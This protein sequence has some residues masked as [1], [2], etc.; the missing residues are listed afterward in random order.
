M[1]FCFYLKNHKFAIQYK[2]M[3]IT[4]LSLSENIYSTN[5]L[6]EE[7]ESR[8]HQVTVVNHTKCSIL[9]GNGSSKVIFEGENIL[10]NADVIIP[11]IGYSVFKHGVAVVKEFENNGIYTTA[12]SM[13]IR[14]SQ[15]KV[16]T[17][18][19]LARKDIA[20]PKTMFSIN[21]DTIDEQIEYIGGAPIIIKL[22]EGTHG[23]GVIL[24]ES[25]KSAKSIIDTFISMDTSIM[26]QEF[27]KESNGEDIRAIVTGDTIVACMKRIGSKDDFRSN[28]HRGGSGQ[29]VQLTHKEEEIVLRAS[30]YLDLPVC[31]V[32]LI[33]SKRGSLLIEVNS[34]PGFQGMEYYTNV[35]VAEKIIKFIEKEYVSK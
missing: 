33:R 14:I 26:L 19:K 16:T 29:R 9:V 34:T 30:K 35:N 21:P 13:G 8:G 20:I 18:Q 5:R 15:N 2:T 27:V 17:L 4:I 1:L 10:N 31:G 6:I 12:S 11:R 7:A 28:I 32:D 3:K 22:Q 25:N 23:L 24:A